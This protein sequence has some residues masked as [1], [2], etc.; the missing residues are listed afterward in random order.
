MVEV[1]LLHVTPLDVVAKATALP[2]RS[3]ESR[4][5]VKRVFDAGHRS[6]TRHGMASFEVKGLSQSIL[7]QLSRHPHISLM[8]TSTRYCDMS[9]DGYFIPGGLKGGYKEKYVEDMQTVMGI[10]QRWLGIEEELGIED[11]AKQLLP[12]A[13]ETDLIVSGN[14]QA[15]Y[16]MLILRSCVRVEEQYRQMV[17]Q[18]VELLEEAVPEIFAGLD[19]KGW[20]LGYCPEV[21]TCGKY[22]LRRDLG[23]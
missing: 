4:G 2:Y 6:I 17:R 19:C 10:Y 12:L 1:N 14:F 21:N 9:K 23:I 22:P 7:R 18:M 8:V 13:S 20:Q 3:K 5:L 11:V 15:F 16:D